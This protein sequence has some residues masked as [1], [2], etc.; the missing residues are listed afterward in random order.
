MVVPMAPSRAE[1]AELHA[2]LVAGDPT[3]SS[4]IFDALLDPLVERLTYKWKTVDRQDLEERAIDSLIAYVSNPQRYDPRR[5]SLLT[6]LTLDADGD[7]KNAYRSA[8]HER[9]QLASDVEDAVSRRNERADVEFFLEEDR[10]FLARLR[11]AFPDERDRRVI[12]LLLEGE[13]STAAYAAALDISGRPV[14]EQRAEVK[15]IKDRIKK[16][17]ARLIEVDE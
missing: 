11:E 15:R 6:Y 4:R 9:E 2:A 7:L 12:Y 1:Q 17:L 16:R 13:R 5:A 3:A 14:D 8:R 10:A